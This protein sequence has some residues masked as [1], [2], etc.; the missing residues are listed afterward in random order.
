[1]M[2]PPTPQAA[3]LHAALAAD[4]WRGSPLR[5]AGLEWMHFVVVGD[6][7]RLLVNLSVR[8]EAT[9]VVPRALVL[10]WDGARWVGGLHTPRRERLELRP[11][12]VDAMFGE[13]SV[14]AVPEG[15]R[16]HLAPKDTGIEA[17]LLLRPE[18]APLVANHLRL[19][20]S[21]R[22][23]WV[24]VPRMIVAEGELR[25]PMTR[26]LSGL[27]A[28][29]DHNWGS[30]DFGGDFAWEWSFGLP[31]KPTDAWSLMALRVS[32]RARHRTLVSGLAVWRDG[33]LW[34]DF[35]TDEVEYLREGSWRGEPHRVPD[36]EVGNQCLVASVP[37]LAK[38][39]ARAG[40]DWLD[41]VGSTD[42]AA[43]LLIPAAA[44][45]VRVTE[46]PTRLTVRGCLRGQVLDCQLNGMLEVVDA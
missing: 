45:L 41:V 30:F 36:I 14:R 9:G 2:H 21:G 37:E 29:H 35:R 40:D 15:Y 39:R 38:W 13:T 4:W 17:D 1:M 43:Q 7:F 18:A 46:C 19:P 44:R 27:S 32:D 31:P 28:Y 16:L 24:S 34:R 11:G 26:S 42:G 10:V 8:R 22:F 20:D 5:G 12:R 33:E 3:H 6:G 23:H 25:A